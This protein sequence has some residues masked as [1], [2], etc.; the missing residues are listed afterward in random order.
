MVLLAILLVCTEAVVGSGLTLVGVIYGAIEMFSGNIG[1][2]I[3]EAGLGIC[4]GGLFLAVGILTYNFASLVLPYCLKQLVSFE[5]Y[6]LKR[7]GPM[8]NRFRR[9]CNKL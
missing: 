8:L 2:G 1:A 3:Y 5:G 4:C 7:I 6:C 9:E